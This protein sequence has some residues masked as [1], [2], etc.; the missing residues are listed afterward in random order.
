MATQNICKYFKSDSANL[1]MLTL[2]Q[3]SYEKI[4]D[5]NILGCVLLNEQSNKL[6]INYLQVNPR[7]TAKKRPVAKNRFFKFIEKHLLCKKETEYKDI[8]RGILDTIKYIY[9]DKNTIE[10]ITDAKAVN[11]YKKNG[12]TQGVF[13]INYMEW[14]RNT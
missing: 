10:L 1:Y 8:G 3:D 2:P 14:H 11:F 4:D 5:K 6:E 12:F 13:H 9:A 7:Y